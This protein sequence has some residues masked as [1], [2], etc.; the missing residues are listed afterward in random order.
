[1]ESEALK[2]LVLERLDDLKAQDVTV[3]DVKGKSPL[4]DLL[5]IATGTSTRHVKSLADAV[6]MKAKEA[7]HMPLGSEGENGSEWVLVDL[8]D[9]ILHVMTAETRDFYNLE[10]LWGV[11]ARET[12]NSSES[13]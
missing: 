8:N 7:G 3:I 1:M 10:K 4:T 2:T 11:G 13:A 5:V 6:E 12:E 9:I